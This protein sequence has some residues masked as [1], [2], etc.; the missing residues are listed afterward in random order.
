MKRTE[1]L[2]RRAGVEV[3]EGKVRRKDIPTVLAA[4]S[5]AKLSEVDAPKQLVDALE[6]LVASYDELFEVQMVLQKIFPFVFDSESLHDGD[7][8]GI[9]LIEKGIELASKSSGS[10]MYFME[11]SAIDGGSESIYYFYFDGSVPDIV[12]KIKKKV[13]K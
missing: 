10:I 3:K 2:I 11:A 4:V 5:T 7:Y 8:D 13:K 12:S 1:K 9:D 6:D